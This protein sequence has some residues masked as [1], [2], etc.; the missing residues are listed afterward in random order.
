MLE[1]IRRPE[2]RIEDFQ[3]ILKEKEEVD[4]ITKFGKSTLSKFHGDYAIDI[5]S[6]KPGMRIFFVIDENGILKDSGGYYDMEAGAEPK[7]LEPADISFIDQ[8]TTIADKIIDETIATF[9]E[10][11]G[12]DPRDKE[13]AMQEKSQKIV[14]GIRDKMINVKNLTVDLCREKSGEL[15]TK[16]S[17]IAPSVVNS[18]KKEDWIIVI[19]KAIMKTQQ[20]DS[21]KAA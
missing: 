2:K 10:N 11:I 12:I 1:I 5:P 18:F 9:Q 16:K 19:R 17:E 8:Q 20:E 7:P 6:D 14:E 4:G 13:I 3:A 15:Q 21:R